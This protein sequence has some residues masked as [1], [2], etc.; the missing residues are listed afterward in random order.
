[1]TRTEELINDYVRITRRSLVNGHFNKKKH[2]GWTKQQEEL[3][4]IIHDNIVNTRTEKIGMNEWYDTSDGWVMQA[5]VNYGEVRFN[6]RAELDVR[7]F[8]KF[9]EDSLCKADS[10]LCNSGWSRPLTI[11]EM[12]TSITQMKNCISIHDDI[13]ALLDKIKQASAFALF[14]ISQI[15]N[16]R[17]ERCNA[18]WKRTYKLRDM[19]DEMQKIWEDENPLKEGDVIDYTDIVDGYRKGTIIAKLSDNE[20]RIKSCKGKS[21]TRKNRDVRRRDDNDFWNSEIGKNIQSCDK[22]II[23]ECWQELGLI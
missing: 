5:N 8:Q 15:K 13:K 3:A 17:D 14:Q 16:R 20:W 10:Q 4:K 11:E 23:P 19:K 12:T 1:M 22:G 7:N 9:I 18:Y 6:Y 2:N 21:I